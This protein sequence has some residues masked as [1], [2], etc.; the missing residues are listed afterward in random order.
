MKR[1]FID[2]GCECGRSGDDVNA[3]EDKDGEWVKWEDVQELINAQK[4]AHNSDYA[5]SSACG[6]TCPN[7]GKWL[8]ITL[9][10]AP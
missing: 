7:C 1:Y 10:V 5:K 4:T 8:N 6:P 9:E 2:T 3:W